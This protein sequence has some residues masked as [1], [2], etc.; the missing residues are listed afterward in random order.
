M[1]GLWQR[2]CFKKWKRADL[3]SNNRVFGSHFHYNI[4]QDGRTGQ[5]TN[6]KVSLVV[7]GN[8]M[9]EGLDFNDSFAPVPHATA[10]RVIISVAAALDLELHS[11]DMAQAF[12]QADKLD[13]GVNG[14]VFI[15]PPK[16][17]CRGA[18]RRL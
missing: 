6:C 8:R 18:R 1:A 14:R 2:K 4:K 5:V 15:T 11:C 7:M 17:I 3:K 9:T 10:A 13:E 16:G 12:M